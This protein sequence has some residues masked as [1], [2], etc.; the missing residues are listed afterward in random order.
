MDLNL[1]EILGRWFQGYAK[2]L[3][4]ACLVVSRNP[5]AN[6][7]AVKDNK[8]RWNKMSSIN[9]N[10]TELQGIKRSLEKNQTR[11]S[12]AADGTAS[13]RV[14]GAIMARRSISSRLAS[15]S[16]SIQELEGQ[17]NQLIGFLGEAAQRYED[18]EALIDRL[19]SGMQDFREKRSTWDWVVDQA[20][21]VGGA[22]KD[23]WKSIDEFAQATLD[24]LNEFTATLCGY[25]DEAIKAINNGLDYLRDLA[26]AAGANPIE[27]YFIT[28]V[29]KGLVDT[30][31]GI[32]KLVVE[33]PTMTTRAILTVE[34]YVTDVVMS[35]DPLAKL[36]DDIMSLPG[37]AEAVYS[38][39]KQAFVDIK[40][41]FVNAD[42]NHKAEMIGFAVEKIAELA[43]PG[44]GEAALAKNAAIG[45]REASVLAREGAEII[46]KSADDVAEGISKGMAERA[47]TDYDRSKLKNWE[48][49]PSD[50]LYLKYKEA[51]DDPT[52]FNQETGEINWPGTKGDPNVDGFVNGK[53]ITETLEEGAVIDRYGSNPTG[54][55]FSPA[56]D[57]FEL[58]ALPPFMETQPYTKYKVIRPFEVKSG[59]IAPWFNQPGKGTQYFTDFTIIDESGNAVKATIQTLIDNG[60]IEIIE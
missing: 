47:I 27:Q 43:I 14:D 35:E 50:E 56:G 23:A 48:Y 38:N 31:G 30:V 28:G 53:Y 12:R 29:L 41:E 60:Y 49:P 25:I 13:V 11:L 18:V 54:Q 10:L 6:E 9:V 33:L 8:R 37:K 52:Y 5:V 24:M 26:I 3:V 2:I 58:R 51:Y 55:Y 32:L 46:A 36:K 39:I 16:R 1:N 59:E 40:T 45:A 17:M 7:E 21:Y 22:V 44:L 57:S 19:V 34:G 20:E 15:A 4:I 42:L